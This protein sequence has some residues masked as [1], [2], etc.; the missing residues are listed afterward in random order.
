MDSETRD[1][2]STSNVLHYQDHI[3]WPIAK[4][5]LIYDYI[6]PQGYVFKQAIVTGLSRSANVLILKPEL[7]NFDLNWDF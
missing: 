2:V 1:A 5:S 7:V 6:M 4:P 3:T